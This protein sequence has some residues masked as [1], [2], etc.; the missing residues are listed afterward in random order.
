M[1]RLTVNYGVRW[2]HIN[3]QNDAYAVPAGRFTPARSIPAV[4]NVPNWSDW[5]PR[6]NMVYDLFGNSKTALKYSLN[7][8]NFAA[9]TALANSFNTLTSTTR[10]LPWT[11][12]NT[13]G[14]AQGNPVV[15]PDGSYAPCVG[16]PSAACEIDMAALRSTNGTWFGTPADADVYSGFPRQWSLE[17]V[18]EVQHELLP[19]L[20]VTA[21]WTRSEDYN[22]RKDHQPFPPG[23]RLRAGH[24]LQPDH[25]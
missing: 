18:L 9:G 22:L 13:D 8:Y 4:K 17:S 16:Y 21:G 20:S 11:D 15:N 10:T 23:R 12:V 2:E 1:K 25:R 3:A 6:F 24:D 19:R 14:I 5:A 7:R